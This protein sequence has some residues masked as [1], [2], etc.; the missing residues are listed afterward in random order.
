MVGVTCGA[1]AGTLFNP[2]VGGVVFFAG[3]TGSYLARSSQDQIQAEEAIVYRLKFL[4]DAAALLLSGK[5]KCH[6]EKILR[7]MGLRIDIFLNDEN[8]GGIS[9]VKFTEQNSGNERILR[10]GSYGEGCVL[11]NSPVLDGVFTSLNRFL[12][13]LG[14]AEELTIKISAE[15]TQGIARLRTAS[16]VQTG[17]ETYNNVGELKESQIRNNNTEYKIR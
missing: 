5:I 9:F 8:D 16:M 12:S 14:F 17:E 7:E 11:V 15:V 3:L 6:G 10:F 4:V 1:V 2:V 13:N